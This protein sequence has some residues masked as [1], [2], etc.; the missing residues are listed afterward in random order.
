MEYS[1]LS[2]A[3]KQGLHW[4]IVDFDAHFENISLDFTN[5]F[6]DD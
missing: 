2:D 3:L 4:R 6:L 1:I 5:K